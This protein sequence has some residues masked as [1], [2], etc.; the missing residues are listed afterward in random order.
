MVWYT[1][2]VYGT[3][4]SER[5]RNFITVFIVATSIGCAMSLSHG[6]R[7][8]YETLVRIQRYSSRALSRLMRIV[9]DT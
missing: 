6:S 8:S 4:D 9:H 1:T 7:L 2:R 5:E 3:G